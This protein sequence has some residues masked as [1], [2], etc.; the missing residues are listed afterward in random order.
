MLR[1]LLDQSYFED[2]EFVNVV[3]QILT[4][5]QIEYYIYPQFILVLKDAGLWYWNTALLQRLQQD[6]RDNFGSFSAD[7]LCLLLRLVNYNFVKD[8]LMQN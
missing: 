1:V 4:E 8:E 5:R 6:F 7:D 2:S 3:M